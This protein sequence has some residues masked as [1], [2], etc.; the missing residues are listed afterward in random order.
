MLWKQPQQ[1]PTARPGG[2]WGHGAMGN[3]KWTGVPLREL[4]DAAKMKQEASFVQ[5]QGLDKGKG[6]EG[7]GSQ[8]LKSLNLKNPVLD[9]CIVAYAMNDERRCPCSTVSRCASSFRLFRHILDEESQL[10]RVLEKPIKIL[11]ENGLSR[12]RHPARQ[13]YA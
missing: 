12:P 2:Q 5:F 6:P 13:H 3:A 9:E 10:I 4:L 8:I 11:D 1:V 7:H